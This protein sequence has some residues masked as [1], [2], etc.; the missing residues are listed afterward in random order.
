M[1]QRHIPLHV[2]HFDCFWMKE[3]QLC[4]FEWDTDLFPDPAAMLS[5]L[6][7]KGL[8]ICV[9]INPYIAQKSGM[10][11]EGKA[12]GY[13][14]KKPDGSVWQWNRWQAGQALVDFTNPAA[15]VWF[16]EKLRKLLKIGVDC[17]K[18]DF[19]RAHTD[20]RCLL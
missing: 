14:V 18:T 16:Q 3:F 1:K 17:F 12:Q 6:K 19:G 5:R 11:A 7:A 13:L 2:F 9:W 10:F 4:D 8:R 20:R 15:V